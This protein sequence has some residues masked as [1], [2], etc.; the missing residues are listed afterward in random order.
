MRKL[1]TWLA[2]LQELG[3]GRLKLL[4]VVTGGHFGIHWF[5]QLF[6]VVLPS[7]KARLGLSDVQVGALSSARQLINGAMDLPCGILADSLARRRAPLLASALLAMGVGYSLMGL[8]PVFALLLFASGLI[9]LGT[10][11]WHPAAAASLSNS[12]P[13][14]RATALSVHGMGATVSDTVTPLIAGFALVSI[15]WTSFLA[16][17]IFPSLIIA[18]LVW[19]GLARQFGQEE[20]PAALSAR[21]RGVITLAKNSTFLGITLA[22]S[23]MQMGRVIVITF[24]PIYLQ[25]HLGYSPFALGVY[26]ALLHAM[27]TVSQPIMGHLSDRFGRKTVLLPS[28]ITLGLLFALLA[29]AAPGIPLGLVVGAIGLFFYTLLNITVAATMDVAGSELQATTYGLSSLLMQI[30]TS[31]TPMAAGWLIGIYGIHSS[32]LVAAAVTIVGALL[33]LPLKL[34]RGNKG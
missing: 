2:S 7:L 21:L 24:L 6:P 32:F 25:E 29:V 30:T 11:L 9:G 28:F 5:Q 8:I 14:R 17:Q 4:A 26:L 16:V 15:P 22:T 34:F 31:P 13:E 10:S 18:L 12:F 27:G 23:F 3:A 19:G 20:L 33:L 1:R